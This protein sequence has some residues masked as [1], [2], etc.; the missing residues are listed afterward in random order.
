[1]NQQRIA[2]LLL[3]WVLAS[4]RLTP[5]PT[6]THTL[7]GPEKRFGELYADVEMAG[8]FPD[9]KTFADH[10][11]LFPDSEILKKYQS[12][13][14]SADFSLETFVEQN[15]AAPQ[16][17][18][19][20]FVADTT[21][22]VSAHIERLWPVLT[23]QPDHESAGTLIPLPHPYIVP[24]GRFREIYYWD[25]YF[26]ML[27]LQVSENASGMIRNMVDN[28]AWLIDTVGFIPNGNRTYYLGRSQ[29][30]FFAMMVNL[31]AE[32]EG[33]TV[34]TDYLPALE[35]EY[36]FWMEGGK[37]PEGGEF[38]VAHV[39]KMPDGEILNRFYDRFPEPRPEAY[40]E[41]VLLAEESGRDKA[42]VY[43]DLRAAAESGW[44]FCSRWF[45]NP[46]QMTTIRTTKIVPVDLN[47]LL[48]TL[49][50]TLAHAW[51]LSGNVQRQQEY[52]KAA[53]KRNDAIMKYCWSEAEGR[54]ADYDIEK[55]AHTSVPSLAMM[56]PLVAGIASEEQAVKVAKWMKEGFLQPGGVTS[57]LNQTGQQWDAPNGW[58]P[59]QWMTIQG[60]RNYNQL[61]LA[62]E[63]KTRWVNIG[64][65]VFQ[66]TGKLTEKY[67]VMDLTLSAGG[68]EY[69]NQ[70]GFGWTNGVL[71]RLLS[72]K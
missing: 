70:D 22:S 66:R 5:E 53:A 30:P 14:T 52:L 6:T 39:V 65:R 33:E 49:E 11:P 69:P 4:C 58:A 32:V 41:D 45:E 19:S 21:Q 29:P 63:I 31:L 67:N 59:L 23:R 13:K 62:N 25:S 9:S 72:E 20:D 12:Q 44:D 42:E 24:G 47:A 55:K 60:L 57:T 51:E 64:S 15:F 48:Y 18:G 61:E 71:L 56:Y 8:I 7:A 37:L 43:G 17:V 34:L 3:V 26:T 36:N 16:V 35:K 50:M 68:G 10:T 2:L 28:F 54:F 27:G 38:A 1:M 40:K 46:Q